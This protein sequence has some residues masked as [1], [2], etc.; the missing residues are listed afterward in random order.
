MYIDL[1]LLIQFNG[2]T[3]FKHLTEDM[4]AQIGLWYHVSPFAG[5]ALLG[6]LVEF[7]REV[8]EHTILHVSA[9]Q[10][11]VFLGVSIALTPEYKRN[12]RSCSQPSKLGL[13][14]FLQLCQIYNIEHT[15]LIS[16]SFHVQTKSQMSS[17]A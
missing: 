3:V 7:W 1:P 4:A 11:E 2:A 13:G 15:K 12:L 10:Y 16:E 9:K 17:F 5:R 6:K 8:A 14:F